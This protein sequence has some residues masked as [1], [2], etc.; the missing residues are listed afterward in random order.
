MNALLA[1]ALQDCLERVEAGE[2]ADAALARHGAL[3]AEL[4]P[5]VL[6]AMLV[7]EH[8][9]LP[10]PGFRARV[11]VALANAELDVAGDIAAARPAAPHRPAWRLLAVRLGAVL[12]AVAMLAGG[13]VVASANSRPGDLLYPVRRGVEQA[14]EAAVEALMPVVTGVQAPRTADEAPVRAPTQAASLAPSRAGNHGT[15]R[16]GSNAAQADSNDAP[17]GDSDPGADTP[18]RPRQR[19]APE[20]RDEDEASPPEVAAIAQ[21]SPAAPTALPTLTAE[22]QSVAAAPEPTASL[23]PVARPPTRPDPGQV[24]ESPPTPQTAHVGP[25]VVP[26]PV[27]VIPMPEMRRSGNPDR[28]GIAGM[29]AREDGSPREGVKLYLYPSWSGGR[30]RPWEDARTGDDGRYQFN[31]LR[32]G[33]YLILAGYTSRRGNPVWRWYPNATDPDNSEEVTVI[34]GYVRDAIDFRFE[35]L[36]WTTVPIPLPI[37]WPRGGS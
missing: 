12:A 22:A 2:P 3:A 33:S 26:A 19:P 30:G 6:A 32:P 16:D 17:S 34:A 37:P 5:L 18:A 13:V 11:Q 36:P 27:E 8:R 28:G 25:T 20:R 31:D 1:D 14:R 29:T 21:E 10:T 15:V 24:P 23:G 7:R 4:R 35:R 9:P